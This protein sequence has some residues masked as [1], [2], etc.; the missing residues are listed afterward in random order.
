MNLLAQ[1]RIAALQAR[2][3]ESLTLVARGGG[4]AFE[5]DFVAV[6]RRLAGSDGG[7]GLLADARSAATDATTR[8]AV[9]AA[10]DHA[11]A[12]LAAH[13]R[14]R[15]LDDRGEYAAAVAIAVGGGPDTTATLSRQLDED[16]DRAIAHTSRQFELEARGAGR[17]LSGADIGLVMLAALL[18]IAAALGIQR[19]IA[20]YR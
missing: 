2:A 1:A 16:L 13:Q 4:A 8:D 3:D 18:G 12:W 7:G 15:A 19:R 10:A 6:M 20:E 11:R 17:A 14:L 5:Q 9:A